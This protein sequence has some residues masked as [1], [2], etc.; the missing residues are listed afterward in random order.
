MENGFRIKK[1]ESSMK[2]HGVR[3]LQRLLQMLTVQ[4][5]PVQKHNWWFHFYIP[6]AA[7]KQIAT[8]STLS[9]IWRSKVTSSCLKCEPRKVGECQQ[10]PTATEVT[11]KHTSAHALPVCTFFNWKLPYFNTC[12][13]MH[14]NASSLLT[15][16]QA[17]RG[18]RL[19]PTQN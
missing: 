3:L 14:R 10:H 17:R 9:H 18:W 19:V 13:E 16:T 5:L 15:L 11:F 1:R 4:S 8:T 7:I 6:L 12:T 2:Q